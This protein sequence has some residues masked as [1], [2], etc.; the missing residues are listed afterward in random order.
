MVVHTKMLGDWMTSLSDKVKYLL[1]NK[2]KGLVYSGDVD[3]VCNWRGGEAWTN[4]LEW[5]GKEE[6]NK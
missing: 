2:V 3:F 6:F 4:A 1:E 5:S